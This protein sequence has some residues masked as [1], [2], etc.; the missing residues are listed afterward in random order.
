[1]ADFAAYECRRCVVIDGCPKCAEKAKNALGADA[2]VCVKDGKYAVISAKMTA[3]AA[4][5]ALA[6]VGLTAAL[7]LPVLD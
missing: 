1:M 6:G 3:D 5:S 4:Q 7:T 2:F